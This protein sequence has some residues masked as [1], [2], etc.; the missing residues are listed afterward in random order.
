MP[1]T[2]LIG[3]KVAV[4]A[5]HQMVAKSSIPSTL[6]FTGP[7]GVGKRTCALAFAQLLTG[8][9][10][11]PLDVHLFSPSGKTQIHPVETMRDLIREASLPPYSAP[12]KVFVIDQAEKMLPSSS[13]ALLKT[14]EEPFPHAI[15]ILITSDRDAMLPTI[16]SR[17]REV[18]F[19]SLPQESIERYLLASGKWTEAEVRKM[20]FLSHGSLG[21]ALD[22]SKRSILPWKED[23]MLLLSFPLLSDYPQCV[24]VLSRLESSIDDADPSSVAALIE[25][26]VMW[27]RDLHLLKEGASIELIYHL[28]HLSQLKQALERPFPTLERLF[29][30]LSQLNLALER[31]IHLRHALERFFRT[32]CT[33]V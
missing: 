21:K 6:L 23:L 4:Q 26:I 2:S 24:Q 20:A 8:Q 10:N 30:A 1:F 17:C 19:F 18:P 29:S 27:Y 33:R 25:E 12:Y 11:S 31:Q 16:V 3:H 5:L 28:D 14:L 7:E 9:K 15:F 32:L 13:N 22:L